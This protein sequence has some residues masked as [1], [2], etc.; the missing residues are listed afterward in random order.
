MAAPAKI[1]ARAELNQQAVIATDNFSGIYRGKRGSHQVLGGA[2]AGFPE[3]SNR[4]ILGTWFQTWCVICGRK[5]V[6]VKQNL[7]ANG[8][9]IPEKAK[10]A[11]ET[12][13]KTG[14]KP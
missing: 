5:P 12:Q 8:R 9:N 11:S 10:L 13:E 3:T 2:R 7:A 14:K 4:T 6:D 1:I